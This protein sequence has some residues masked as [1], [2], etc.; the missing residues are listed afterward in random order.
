MSTYLQAELTELSQENHQIK[1]KMLPTNDCTVL[2]RYETKFFEYVSKAF[3]RLPSKSDYLMYWCDDTGLLL[4]WT[5]GPCNT[6]V[7]SIFSFASSDGKLGYHVLPNIGVVLNGL[8]IMKRRDPSI[9]LPL[10]TTWLRALAVVDFTT[11]KKPLV[12]AYTAVSNKSIM[13]E[14]L[15]NFNHRGTKLTQ[16]EALDDAGR[17]DIIEAQ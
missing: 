10:I 9:I 4:S 16:F 3:V 2:A 17:M 13:G 14:L 15:G 12:W 5:H 11:R 1:D 7:E 6:S 8:N